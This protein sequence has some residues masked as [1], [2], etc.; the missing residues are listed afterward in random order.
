MWIV[1]PKAQCPI[2]AYR[3]GVVRVWTKDQLPNLIFVTSKRAMNPLATQI[4]KRIPGAKRRMAPVGFNDSRIGAE[5]K[6]SPRA[7]PLGPKG[8][9]LRLAVWTVE[10]G[11]PFLIRAQQ[12]PSVWAGNDREHSA[13]MN[14]DGVSN[15][16]TPEVPQANCAVRAAG[17]NE[18]VGDKGSAGGMFH[19]HRESAAQALP[20]GV[21]NS[22]PTTGTTGDYLATVRTEDN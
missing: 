11:I 8:L 21:A 5:R 18:T 4:K 22:Y 15:G 14:R 2:V 3:K 7:G 6:E 12:T 20:V 9:A 13:R 19:V 1:S 16:L 17:N 10:P